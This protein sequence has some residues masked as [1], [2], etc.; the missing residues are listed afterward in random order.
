MKIISH[1]S[2]CLLL[3]S[4]LFVCSA[5]L[6]PAQT[7]GDDPGIQPCKKWR[8]RIDP[9]LTPVKEPMPA[10]YESPTPRAF[11]ITSA[12]SVKTESIT[13]NDFFEAA[14]CLLKFK[15]N[16][17]DSKI[18]G[19][20]RPDTSQTFGAA[21]IEVAALYYISYLYREKWG[22]AGAAVLVDDYMELGAKEIISK[23]YESYEKWVKK[24]KE[25]GLDEARKQNLDPLAQSGIQWY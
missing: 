9:G 14:E 12:V 7:R 4:F 3:F 23:A 8:V 13:E 2:N 1:L 16:T 15:G 10:K 17:N 6:T 24:V 5:V 25:V 11:S 21:S 20:T 18:V 19:A 22:H